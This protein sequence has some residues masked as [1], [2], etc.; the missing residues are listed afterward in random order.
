MS[1]DNGMMKQLARLGVM[2]MVGVTMNANAGLFGFGSSTMSWKEEVQLHDGHIIVAERFYNL[3]AK[4][5]L[6]S[7]ERAALDETVTFSLPD[8]NKKIIWK[9]DF[10]DSVVSAIL[11]NRVIV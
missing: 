9:N 6:E 7:R 5:T 1:I 11:C 2:L 3:G 10:K 4:P 8:T